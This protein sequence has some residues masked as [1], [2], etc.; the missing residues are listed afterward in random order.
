MGDFSSSELVKINS[1]RNTVLFG[2]SRRG[3]QT[4]IIEGATSHAEQKLGVLG[5]KLLLPGQVFALDATNNQLTIGGV[6]SLSEDLPAEG[7]FV[8]TP[9]GDVKPSHLQLNLDSSTGT[10]TVGRIGGDVWIS[11]EDSSSPVHL[12]GGAYDYPIEVSTKPGRVPPGRYINFGSR[13]LPEQIEFI[14]LQDGKAIFQYCGVEPDKLADVLRKGVSPFGGAT[15]E[16]NPDIM[17]QYALLVRMTGA[18]KRANE[19]LRISRKIAK[20]AA[21]MMA[22]TFGYAAASAAIADTFGIIPAL[23]GG[24]V[25]TGT[26]LFSAA[27]LVGGVGG[28]LE[29]SG[30]SRSL[31]NKTLDYFPDLGLPED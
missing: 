22:A 29:A 13:E 8:F 25:G 15:T 6:R 2:D 1:G 5:E 26:A 31:I 7:V 3:I 17:N 11:T 12:G 9:H 27:G 19:S 16:Q 23:L 24:A 20:G 18:I 4:K 28:A 14:G 21:V 30:T 10:V